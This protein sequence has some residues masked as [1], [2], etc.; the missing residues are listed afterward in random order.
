[1]PYPDPEYPIGH[2]VRNRFGKSLTVVAHVRKDQIL[3]PHGFRLFSDEDA[4]RAPW[5]YTLRDAAGRET[6]TGPIAIRQM[7]QDA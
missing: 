1:M 2:T 7:T 6:D 4:R 5:F 3:T